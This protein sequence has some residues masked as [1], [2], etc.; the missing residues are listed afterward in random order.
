MATLTGC[1][2]VYNTS[3][4]FISSRRAITI[5]LR[6]LYDRDFLFHLPSPSPTMHTPPSIYVFRRT[7][8]FYQ[9]RGRSLFAIPGAV[10]YTE[11][12]STYNNIDIGR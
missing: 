12:Y 8:F 2:V 9:L 10:A 7:R 4:E 11:T 1:R 6:K 3:P 5:L